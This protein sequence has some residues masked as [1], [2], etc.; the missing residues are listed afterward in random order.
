MQGYCASFVS[1]LSNNTLLLSYQVM[2]LR[3][4]V[5]V[6]KKSVALALKDGLGKRLPDIV[7]VVFCAFLFP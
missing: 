3:E 1:F 6:N 5:E 2:S 7:L 4:F